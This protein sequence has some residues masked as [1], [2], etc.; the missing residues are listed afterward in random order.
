M[1]VSVFV[2]AP[3]SSTTYAAADPVFM[4]V[5]RTCN[6]WARFRRISRWGDK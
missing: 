2:F 5:S 6:Y 1:R 3:G 4:K